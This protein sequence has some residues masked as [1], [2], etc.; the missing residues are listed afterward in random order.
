MNFLDRLPVCRG[1]QPSKQ[2][3]DIQALYL[4]RHRRD[5]FLLGKGVFSVNCT[6]VL[7]PRST[8]YGPDYKACSGCLALVK[9]IRTFS[10]RK[11]KRIE[12]GLLSRENFGGCLLKVR[13]LTFWGQPLE[14]VWV[15]H[16][17]TFVAS[18]AYIVC[19]C[20]FEYCVC[21]CF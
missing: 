5:G 2:M 18:Y 7:E 6:G 21:L 8:N 4:E 1:C 20:A 16:V 13:F 14:C 12:E 15:V 3:P 9:R 19:V 11:R 10:T 17:N